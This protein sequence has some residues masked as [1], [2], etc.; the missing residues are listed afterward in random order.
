MQGSDDGSTRHF[1]NVF[2]KDFL[3]RLGERNEPRTSAE[4]DVAGPW[5]VEAHCLTWYGVYRRGE[6][7]TRGHLPAGAFADL[8]HAL[9]AAA[10]LPGT[11]REPLFHLRK[12]RTPDGY[13]VESGGE[14]IAHLTH[15][16]EKLVDA[17]HVLESILRSPD[18]L[19]N[20]LEAAGSVALERAGAILDGRVRGE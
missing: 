18:A 9:L 11:G 5:G 10:A 7:A 15:F 6:S 8:S 13:A 17:L 3:R 20:L 1:G 19:A 16:D 2:L 12:D 4:A 14:V